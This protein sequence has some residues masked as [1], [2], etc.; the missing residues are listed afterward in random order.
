MDSDEKIKLVAVLV[1]GALVVSGYVLK[2]E[3][4]MAIK[5]AMHTVRV[6]SIDFYKIWIV[7]GS[8]G[9]IITSVAL[10]GFVFVEQTLMSY[11]GYAVF[12]LGAI[13]WPWVITSVYQGNEALSLLV[14][15]SGTVLWA[16][17]TPWTWATPFVVGT[18]LYHCIVD[19]SMYSA[20][21]NPAKYN[22]FMGW[23]G[24]MSLLHLMGWAFTVQYTEPVNIQLNLPFNKWNGTD[25]CITNCFDETATQGYG[26]FNLTSMV[27][28]YCLVSFI[29]HA[30]VYLGLGYRLEMVVEQVNGLNGNIFRYI[31]WAFSMGLIYG[32]LYIML[33]GSLSVTAMNSIFIA[34]FGIV[35]LSHASETTAKRWLSLFYIICCGSFYILLLLPLFGMAYNTEQHVFQPPSVVT[36]LMVWTI[37][38]YMCMGIVRIFQVARYIEYPHTYE[39]IYLCAGIYIKLVSVFAYHSIVVVDNLIVGTNS[40]I[41]TGVGVTLM[42]TLIISLLCYFLYGKTSNV[43]GTVLLLNAEL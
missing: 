18:S 32:V 28:L 2:W 4:I 23:S 27:A 31:D 15:A 24:L 19:T 8:F 43:S 33:D 37:L 5:G 41:Y 13:T 42:V 20:V 34:S 14:T 39:V 22:T 10:V 6:R 17:G 7:C 38:S 1:L 30:C 11:I 21:M 9:F 29:H 36:F 35:F 16:V 40:S 25:G 3:T 12:M 26:T